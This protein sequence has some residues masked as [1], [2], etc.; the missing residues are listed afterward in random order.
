MTETTSNAIAPECQCYRYAP[1]LKQSRLRTLG[2]AKVIAVLVL[3]SGLQTGHLPK[4]WHD[5][6][7][8]DT[9]SKK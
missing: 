7:E 5:P 2:A 6:I 4:S 9:I 3:R 8:P 1:T